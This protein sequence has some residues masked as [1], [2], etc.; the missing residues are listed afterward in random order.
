MRQIWLLALNDLRL[1]ARDRP[2]FFWIL[3]LPIGMMW[4]FGSMGGGNAS[5]PPTISLD[6]VNH[7]EGWISRAFVD[8]LRAD[9]VQMRE[10][11]ADESAAAADRVRTLVI[12]EGFTAGVL[13]GEQ[14]T[15]RLEREP[16]SNE[17]FG[18]AAQVHVTRAIVRT[19]GRLVEMGGEGSEPTSDASLEEQRF[20]DLGERPRLVS[21]VVSSAGQG[22]PVPSGR[23]QSVPGILTFTVLM[24]TLIYGAVFLTLEKSSGMLRRQAVL[25]MPR[26]SLF[27]GKLLGRLLLAA[28][29][30]LLLILAGRYVFGISWGTSVP[31]LFLVLTSYATAVA[32]MATLLGAV[33][34]TP[35]QASSVGWIVAM[36]MA[37]IGGCWWPA[38]VM[39]RWMWSAAHV[40]PTAWAMQ[41]FHA[42]ITFGYGIEAV[43]VPSLVLFGF[44]ALSALLGVRFLRF[45]S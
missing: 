16:D 39:P 33:L 1:T 37:A 40:V 29:Q 30:I 38:E 15:V 13:G 24:M 11:T 26:S 20:R 36:V 25:P 41:A 5:G 8:E 45:E 28:I 6:V 17:S 7:D 22:Q 2:A 14:Q 43:I 44:G 34:R 23:A 10:F 4:L 3:V 31:A 9:T 32:G 27:L 12:P 21:L 18:I 19:L 35:A 42:L